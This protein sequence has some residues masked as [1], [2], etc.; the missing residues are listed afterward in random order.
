MLASSNVAATVQSNTSNLENPL[1]SESQSSRESPN[2][3]IHPV[4][5]R[6]VLTSAQ[7]AISYEQV[8]TVEYSLAGQAP[9]GA[10]AEFLLQ[11]LSHL[12]AETMLPQPS[13]SLHDFLQ[14]TTATE[15]FTHDSVSSAFE[16]SNNSPDASMHE[17]KNH[18]IHLDTSILPYIS[19]HFH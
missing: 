1:Y 10:L 9:S 18:L 4:Q 11:H 17:D 6:F 5:D 14:H 3:P 15:S 19:E 2:S 8:P 16:S 7:E 13:L 12:A